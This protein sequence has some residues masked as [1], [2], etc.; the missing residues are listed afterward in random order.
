MLFCRLL[1][2]LVPPRVAPHCPLGVG[3][4]HVTLL[5]HEDVHSLFRVWLSM[6]SLPL[7]LGKQ[8]DDD[9]RPSARVLGW[10][11]PS[12]AVCRGHGP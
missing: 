7:V 6:C 11:Q 4:A 2:P 5:G 9:G 12:P 3:C 8:R 1:L 10:R